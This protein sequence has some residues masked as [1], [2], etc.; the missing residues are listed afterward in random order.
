MEIEFLL[1]IV[2]VLFF[3]SILVSKAGNWL[4]VPVLLLF[5][6]VGMLF[7]TDGLRL[8]DFNNIKAANMIGTLSLCAIL[9]SGGLDT[10]YK[11]IKPVL[12]P[13]VVLATLGVL[14]TALTTGL[15][16][17]LLMG[18]RGGVVGTVIGCM[19]LA[20]TMSS[21]DSASVFSILRSKGLNLKHNLRPTLEMESG[22]NDPMAYVMTITFISLV[23]Q[24]GSPNYWSAIGVLITQLIIGT[25]AGLVLGQC[26]V[27]LINRINIDNVSFYPILVLTGCFF[28]FSVTHYLHGNSYLAV[29]LAGLIVGNSKFVHKRST[30]SFFEGISWLCQL[31]MFLTLGLLVNP[32]ELK[33]VLVPG[34]IISVVMIF[35]TRPLSVFV[36]L[37][38][39]RQYGFRDKVFVSWVGLRGAVPIIFAIL[40]KASGIP[41][42]DT[43]F[44]IVFLCTL[45]SLIVQG[46]TLS[47]MARWLG[48]SEPPEQKP[49]MDNFD[50]EFPE[51]IKSA[52]SEIEITRIMLSG[53]SRL[54]DLGMPEKTLAI[55]VKRDDNY[56]VPTGVTQLH[57]GDRLMILTDN[58][59]ALEATLKHLNTK[60]NR[61]HI[62]R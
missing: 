18:N 61:T 8:L 4:G 26:M 14:I 16:L 38:F 30:R 47:P 31:T 2:S 20:S 15:I 55:M 6:A 50:I 24:G 40:C 12:A 34:L 37:A 27:G 5:L 32:S 22:S 21:T 57:E 52:A 7:G 23:M 48:V 53:G 44:N 54:M 43:I 46:T 56:F 1:L 60:R 36:S 28:V 13:G 17:Y 3:V 42:S 45:V 25:V 41:D 11:E 39:F 59:E 35:V 10:K 51:E 19:L 58:Q 33:S 62:Q 9:F 49:K 29:Y